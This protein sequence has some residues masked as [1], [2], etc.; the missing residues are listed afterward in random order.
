LSIR[1]TPTH[2]PTHLTRRNLYQVLLE[3]LKRVDALLFHYLIN[4]SAAA[5][6]A[7]AA[8]AA[9][10]PGPSLINAD[11][12]DAQQHLSGSSSISISRD[13]QPPRGGSSA[14]QR[15][16]VLD[17]SML[18]FTRGALTFGTGMQLK[19]ACTR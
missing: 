10:P 2:P 17:E 12:T 3:L 13:G 15:V 19:M 8:A 9:A 7:A 16:P 6:P 4:P 11:A 14:Q 1:T 18:F 5:P